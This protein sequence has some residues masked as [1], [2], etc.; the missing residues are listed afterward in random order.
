MPS[1]IED[2]IKEH[3]QIAAERTNFDALNQEVAEYVLPEHANFTTKDTVQGSQRSRRQ[4]DTTAATE[5]E[6]H[7]AAID[8]LATPAGQKW[9]GLAAMDPRLNERDDVQQYFDDVL[10]I[11]RAERAA[12]NF[13][14]QIFDV[15]HH[16][17]VLGTS[18]F[19]ILDKSGGGL[20]YRCLPTSESYIAV[21]AEMEVCRLDRRFKLTAKA[22]HGEYGDAL[23]QRIKDCLAEKPNQKFEFLHVI[24]K[25][26]ARQAGYIDARGMGWVSV[27]IALEDKQGLREGGFSSWPAPVY[28]YAKAPDEWYGR[29]WAARVLPTIRQVNKMVRA[30]D[31]QTEKAAD[32]PLL[33]Y[34]DGSLGYGDDA[35]GNTPSL[36]AGDI[37]WGGM[38]NDGKPLVAGLYT[39]AD[40]NKGW[41]RVA[42]R[43]QEIKDAALTSVFQIFQDRERMTATE[44]L[45]IMQE[46]AQLTVPVVGRAVVRFL[47]KVLE[48]ELEI[49]NRQGKLPPMPRALAKAGGVYQVTFN[50]P[51]MR[52]LKLQEVTA[53]QTLVGQMVPLLQFKPEL[54]EL[55]DWEKMF[56]D[57]GSALGVPADWITDKDVL[58][59]RAKQRAQQQQM[60]SVV[61]AA[62][63]IA[64]ALKDVAQAGAI[65]RGA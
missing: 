62:P 20:R 47:T 18:P 21:D 41:E 48:R 6:R 55:L 10:D 28:R 12:S 26:P 57:S 56:R 52:L 4:Y 9:D 19:L 46:K 45:G 30:M 27:E 25:N 44:F 24:M 51:L 15:W 40:L 37:H 49:L 13:Q 42:K 43:Q 61:A 2:L 35:S 14:E 36:G 50:S 65:A 34:D 17:G 29:G 31:R 23:P 1:T 53:G 3:Q 16:G 58:A 38:T 39:N 5:A 33:A 7:A 60:Q 59:A 22:A 32:P 8:S 11:L 54:T 63:E 64:G